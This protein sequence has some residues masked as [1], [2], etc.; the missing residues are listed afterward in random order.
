MWWGTG[1]DAVRTG[2]QNVIALKDGNA[3][4]RADS[5]VNS[6]PLLGGPDSGV[7]NIHNLGRGV[8]AHE[9]THLLNVY[10]KSGSV[11]SNTSLL[12]DPTVPRH[13]TAQDFRWGVRE[14]IRD[15]R[16]THLSIWQNGGG[17]VNPLTTTT[18]IRAPYLWW[19]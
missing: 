1:H 6:R 12:N 17:T 18:V 9:F 5:F 15:N 11:L 19:K 16:V 3:T 14:A 8:A 7:W 13:A 2:A 10:D 4:S